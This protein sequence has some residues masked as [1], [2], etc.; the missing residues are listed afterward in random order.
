MT[1][2]ID[3][4]SGLT[5]AQTEAANLIAQGVKAVDVAEAVGVD[6]STVSRWRR[7]AP[8]AAL[9]QRINSEAHLEVI[10][11]MTDLTNR[12]LDV[13]EDLLD[14]RHDPGVKLRAAIAIVN[15]SGITRMTRASAHAAEAVEPDGA[16][17]T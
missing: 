6:E 3:I 15:A 11:R 16:S 8:F 5:E 17:M 9:V 1:D 2:A 10:G 13:L 12:A 14:Y 7:K 4:T